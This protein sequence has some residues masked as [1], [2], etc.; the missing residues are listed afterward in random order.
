MRCPCCLTRSRSRCLILVRRPPG[1]LTFAPVASVWM[2]QD[3]KPCPRH[4]SASALPPSAH[5]YA[6]W[7]DQPQAP[8]ATLVSVSDHYRARAGSRVTFSTSWWHS[9]PGRVGHERDVSGA[10]EEVNDPTQE[11]HGTK[12]R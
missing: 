12:N 2:R 7:P 3:N 10:D 9:L 5:I 4:D 6:C 8:L 11:P 1:C